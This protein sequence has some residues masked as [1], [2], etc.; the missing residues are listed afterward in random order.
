MFYERIWLGY[1]YVTIW[2]WCVY[3]TIWLWYVY[4]MI[5]PWYVRDTT[6]LWDDMWMLWHVI[7]WCTDDMINVMVYT[8]GDIVHD[9]IKM[10]WYEEKWKELSYIIKNKN[11]MVALPNGTSTALDNARPTMKGAQEV[12]ESTG[13]F[14]LARVDHL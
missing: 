10:I 13:G 9:M 7:W 12:Y 14:I 5:S 4:E 8:F 11:D 6:W 2:L 3:K 1:V